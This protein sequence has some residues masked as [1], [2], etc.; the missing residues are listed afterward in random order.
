MIFHSRAHKKRTKIT[1][2]AYTLFCALVLASAQQATAPMPKTTAAAVAAAYGL[3][4]SAILETQDVTGDGKLLRHVLVRGTGATAKKGQTVFAHYDGK[5]AMTAVQFDSSRKRGQ[6]FSFPLGAG[7]VI[8]GWD[9]G[10]EG[11]KI[12]EKAILQI[13]SSLGC[14]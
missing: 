5:L 9:L 14:K 11:L 7:R 6:P 10:F 3:A 12:G 4:A 13:D 2:R 8:K 1:M